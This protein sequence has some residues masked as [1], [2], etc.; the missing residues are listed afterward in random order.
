MTNQLFLKPDEGKF[1]GMAVIA[2]IEQLRESNQNQNIN[3]NPETRKSLK[4]MLAA[5]NSLRIKLEKLGFDCR[6]LPPY[7]DGEETDFLTK[8]S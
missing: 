8:P 1:L 2:I 6:D 4:D 5:G 7:I 3:W